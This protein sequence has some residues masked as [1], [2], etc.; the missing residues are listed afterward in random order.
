MEY[1]AIYYMYRAIARSAL[2]HLASAQV[3]GLSHSRSARP[4]PARSAAG[5]AHLGGGGSVTTP[6]HGSTA[7]LRGSLRVYTTRS[8]GVGGMSLTI[9]SWKRYTYTPTSV[10][11]T[12]RGRRGGGGALVWA[13]RGRRAPARGR[14][15]AAPPM[16]GQAG[17][18]S[19]WPKR[20]QLAH[21]FRWEYSCKRLKLAQFLGQL[22]VF[23]TQAGGEFVFLQ[24]ALLYRWIVPKR[25]ERP[26]RT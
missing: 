5:A 16:P 17:K 20:W 23:L 6:G 11:N 19:G 10:R 12:E 9:L 14:G 22:G 1:K 15:R 21:A 3:R 4:R 26:A 13:R 24:A 7:I 8:G 18:L 2:Y 25:N